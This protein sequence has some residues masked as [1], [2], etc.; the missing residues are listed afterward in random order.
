MK[1]GLVCL[2][3]VLAVCFV[4]A[5]VMACDPDQGGCGDDHGNG[6]GNGGGCGGGGCGG[7]GGEGDPDDDHDC[8]GGQ[9]PLPK[10]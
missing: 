8:G 1:F 9:C 10:P 7:C 6:G 3:I 2:L 4:A 5:P